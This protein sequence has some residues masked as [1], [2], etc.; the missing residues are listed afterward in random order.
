MSRKT[1]SDNANTGRE[2]ERVNHNRQPASKPP[3][4]QPPKR[5]P[6]PP[7][8][9]FLTGFWK[10]RFSDDDYRQQP[11]RRGMPSPADMNYH[12]TNT[13]DPVEPPHNPPPPEPKKKFCTIL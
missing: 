13:Y 12:D 7:G 5:E 1:K 11:D 9:S 10:E 8:P 4:P 6:P 2:P 3:Q